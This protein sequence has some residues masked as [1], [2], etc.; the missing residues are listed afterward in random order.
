MYCTCN[1]YEYVDSFILSENP[2]VVLHNNQS[3]LYVNNLSL[4]QPKLVQ[5]EMYHLHI[6]QVLAL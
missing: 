6:T 3:I 2:V 4:L 5:Q 1:Q